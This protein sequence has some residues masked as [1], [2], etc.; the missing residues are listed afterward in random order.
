[1]KEKD[2]LHAA[3][4]LRALVIERNITHL[5]TQIAQQEA[6]EL[7]NRTRKLD[8]EVMCAS[9]DL[10]RAATADIPETFNVVIGGDNNTEKEM[11]AKLVTIQLWE[12]PKKEYHPPA[13]TTIVKIPKDFALDKAVGETFAA[14]VGFKPEDRDVDEYM[15]KS[16]AQRYD[17]KT[18]SLDEET[19]A[20]VRLTDRV[21]ESLD[22]QHNEDMSPWDSTTE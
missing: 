17:E 2:V 14:S 1:M 21:M 9:G 4:K 6:S 8:H 5:K 13:C 10:S 15:A 11:I 22:I 7:H 3:E 20:M 12:K 18:K 19:V 16:F